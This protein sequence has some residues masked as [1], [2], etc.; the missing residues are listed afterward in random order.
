MK[1]CMHLVVKCCAEHHIHTLQLTARS[2]GCHRPSW[3]LSKGQIKASDRNH[4]VRSG[5][6]EGWA[7][8]EGEGRVVVGTNQSSPVGKEQDAS[9]V[10]ATTHKATRTKPNRHLS[11]T[12]R[13]RF[14]SPTAGC[15]C[16]NR[17]AAPDACQRF[18]YIFC[19]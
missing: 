1:A 11:N 15:C 6:H 2:G 9:T 10:D 4:P 12:D 14:I 13:D 7:S 3:L 18:I 19:L 16:L 8:W 17:N 5:A